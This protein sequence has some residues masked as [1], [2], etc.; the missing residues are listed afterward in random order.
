MSY[1]PAAPGAAEIR[2]WRQ[3]R[4]FWAGVA[5]GLLLL[6]PFGGHFTRLLF[7]CPFKSLTGYPCPTCGVTRSA[8]ALSHFDFAGALL[9]YPLA[10]LAWLF[11]I[12]GGLLAGLSVLLGIP[13]PPPPQR[14]RPWQR[15]TLMAAVLANWAYSIATGV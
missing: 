12:G 6:A 7:A 11:L 1:L 4:I 8:L 5:L 13:L 15:W 9:H 2:A 14:L 10:T 3:L